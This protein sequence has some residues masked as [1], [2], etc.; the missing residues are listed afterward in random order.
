MGVLGTHSTFRIHSVTW[1]MIQG[2]RIK[3]KVCL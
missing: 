2:T 1:L 3:M